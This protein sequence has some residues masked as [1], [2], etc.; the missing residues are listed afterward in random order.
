LTSAAGAPS[1]VTDETDET[2]AP[3]D[4]KDATVFT[5]DDTGGGVNDPRGGGTANLDGSDGKSSAGMDFVFSK[6]DVIVLVG[7]TDF[8][9]GRDVRLAFELFENDESSSIRGVT[10]AGLGGV[11]ICAHLVAT[12]LPAFRPN[13]LTRFLKV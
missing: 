3:S 9:F 13:L 6:M 5:E 7:A 11:L 4:V 8:F 1:D 2:G 10:V 12:S